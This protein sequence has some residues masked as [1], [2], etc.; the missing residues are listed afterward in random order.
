MKILFVTSTRI[1]DAVLSTGLLDHLLARHA[2]ARIT[3]ACGPDAAPLFEAVPKLD[4]IIVVAKRRFSLHWP[5]LWAQTAGTVWDLVVDLRGSALAWLL[6]ARRRRTYRADGAAMH[7]V[8]RYAGVLGLGEPPA[9]RI[10]RLP[11]HD[12]AAEKLIPAGVPVLAVA[13]TGNWR[14]KIWPAENF[15]ELVRRLTGPDGIMAGARIAV[16]G[17]A[18]EREGTAAVMA[19]VA[20][21]NCI[22]LI[23]KV[24]LLTVSACLGRCALYVGNDTGLTHLA[25]ASG[26]PTLALFGPTN[27]LH[28]AP[29]GERT[30]YVATSV[31]YRDLVG[32]P[33]FD[34]RN[35][36]NL[37]G[38]LS[39]AAVSEAAEVLWRRSP[40]RAA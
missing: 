19:A 29:W 36:D 7:R 27:A 28:Y 25:A 17:S 13:P 2:D 1:G 9:P 18:D 14:P 24:D 30:A 16:F 32:A 35:H 34:Y 22:D 10:W 4:R 33:D 8:E 21:E 6:M 37:M 20:P 31:E 38:S 3:I 23:G 39:V 26:V 40:Q 11:G 12:A 5:A 15:A